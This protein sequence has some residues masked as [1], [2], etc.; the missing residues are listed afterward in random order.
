MS[1]YM[2][3]L[4]LMVALSYLLGSIPTA[5][6]A[7]KI[8]KN[9]DIRTQGSGNAGATNVFRVLGWKAGLTVLLIDMVKGLL[10]TTVVYKIALG[11]V[12]V[13]EELLQII[14]GLS[15]VFGHIWTIFAGFK[16]GK[17]VG[18]GAGMVIGIVPGAVLVGL[19]IFMMVVAITR[20][21]SLGSILASLTV[22]V[23]I[24][25]DYFFLNHPTSI[26]II[27]FG[28]FIPLL[29]IFTHRSNIKR[30]V[31]GKENKIQ[32]KKHN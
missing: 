2:V 5:I 7:G 8:L 21:V 16:G 6:I 22:P 24:L 25:I 28:C 1:I 19:V 29:I 27:I 15:A 23:Y 12:M 13:G 11:E 20:F 4:I 3:N 10:A 9:I 17:G 30:L 32:F 14:A 18:T 26:T 31:N